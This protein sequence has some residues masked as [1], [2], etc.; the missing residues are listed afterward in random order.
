MTDEELIQE[1]RRDVSQYDCNIRAAA[2]EEAKDKMRW[3][4]DRISLAADCLEELTNF[5]T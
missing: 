2:T 5:E 1:L 3:Y 4:R